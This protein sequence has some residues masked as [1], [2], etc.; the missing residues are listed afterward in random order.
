MIAEQLLFLGYPRVLTTDL[1]NE[2]GI[3]FPGYEYV[4]PDQTSGTSKEP[5]WELSYSL[6]EIGRASCR[7]RV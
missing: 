6:K 7:E 5:Y 4:T 2:L 3:E 1:V